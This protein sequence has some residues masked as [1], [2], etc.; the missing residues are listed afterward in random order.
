MDLLPYAV[1]FLFSFYMIELGL[2]LGIVFS[3]FLILYPV[4]NPKVEEEFKEV[5]VLRVCNGLFYPGIDHITDI[6]EEIIYKPNSP[7]TIMLDM[8]GVS[9]MDYTIIAGIVDLRNNILLVS[10]SKE[11]IVTNLCDSLKPMFIMANLGD[12]LVESIDIFERYE[13]GQGLLTK[14]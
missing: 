14:R 4:M 11:L 10:P 12:T 5:I 9:N 1:T 7:N 6:I 3:I 13:E 8:H 2:L